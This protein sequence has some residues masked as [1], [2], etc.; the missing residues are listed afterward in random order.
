MNRRNFLPLN[1]S[2]PHSRKR[3]RKQ[4]PIHNSECQRRVN[5][6]TFPKMRMSAIRSNTVLVFANVDREGDPDGEEHA[7]VDEFEGEGKVCVGEGTVDHA[8][9]HDPDQGE[10]G[11]D[12]LE[13]SLCAGGGGGLQQRR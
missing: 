10:E 7:P 8:G 5:R 6:I 3:H 1:N 4:N 11:P 9:G 2:I 12:T 13:V